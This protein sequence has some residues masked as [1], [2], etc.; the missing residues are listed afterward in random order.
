MAIGEWGSSVITPVV[1]SMLRTI[2][3]LAAAAY[4][5]RPDGAMA[6]SR[7]TL[8]SWVE[9]ASVKAAVLRSTLNVSAFKSAGL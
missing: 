3:P 5:N 7:G 4:R 2:R 9:W 1:G 6:L 8:E